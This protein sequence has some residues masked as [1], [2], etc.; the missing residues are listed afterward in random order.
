MVSTDCAVTFVMAG[1]VTVPA[2]QGLLQHSV[3]PRGTGNLWLIQRSWA[4]TRS[5]FSELMIRPSEL[6]SY[7]INCLC[8][9]SFSTVLVSS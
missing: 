1:D 3:V 2:L 6:I 9:N 4:G 7:K 5:D 8:S